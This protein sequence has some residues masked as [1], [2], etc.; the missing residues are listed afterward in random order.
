MSNV[1]VLKPEDD[2]DRFATIRADALTAEEQCSVIN[3]A[4]EVL[5]QQHQPGEAFSKP[6]QTQH[7]L[8]LR[9][10][11]R[12][13][14]LF[15]VLFMDNLNRL[16]RNEELFTGS[17]NSASV[18]PRVVVQRALEINAASVILFHNHPSGRPEPSHSDQTFTRRLSEAL[19]LI[20]VRVLDHI[21]VGKEGAVSFA[22]RGLI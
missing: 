5:E 21:V 14:E 11:E 8:R 6:E 1:V 12:P 13:N 22:E 2:A 15:G 17:I 18:Y 9:Y 7:Y 4:L 16:L 20:D 3:L 10:G 19:Q